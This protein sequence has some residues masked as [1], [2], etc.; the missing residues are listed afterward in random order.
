MVSLKGLFIGL[1]SVGGELYDGRAS[2]PSVAVVAARSR[3]GIDAASAFGRWSAA[4][5]V[6]GN[7]AERL[8]TDLDRP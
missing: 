6:L 2:A 7:A 5:K 4:E 1:V 8:A 3:P